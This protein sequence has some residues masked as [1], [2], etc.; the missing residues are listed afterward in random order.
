MNYDLLIQQEGWEIKGKGESGQ[1]IAEGQI[2]EYTHPFAIHS[3][4][5]R[6]S[7][8]P[9]IKFNHL[10]AM[11]RYAWPDYEETWNY[12]DERR[13]RALCRGY[14]Y[15]SYAGG[16]STGKSDCAGRLALLY[17]LCA[18]HKRTV[19]VA[20]TT[21]GSAQR[22]IWGYIT[23]LRSE[24]KI[25][26][27]FQAY[28]GNNPRL[29]YNKDD[30][31]HGMYAVAAGRGTDEKVISNWIGNHPKEAIL[32]ILDEATELEP[33]LLKSLVN[34]ES[35][36]I[37][38]C[39]MA[40]GNS[41][42]RNDLHGMM[43]TPKIGWEKLDPD[44]TNEWE[45]TQKNG[46]CLYFNCDESP[47]IFEKNADKKKKLSRFFITETQIAEKKKLY[48]EKGVSYLRF[49]KGLW[50][51]ENVDETIVS[52]TFINDFN[53]R[54]NAEWFG[55]ERMQMCAGLDPAFSQGGDKCILQMG[56]LGTDTAGNVVLDFRNGKLRHEVPVLVG[57]KSI[58]LQICEYVLRLLRQYK[59]SLGS[60]CIDA[61][62]QG[63]ALGELLRQTAMNLG[64]SD[65]STEMPLKI[66]STKAGSVKQKSFDVIIKTNYELWSTVKAFIQTRQLRGVDPITVSQLT[67]RM[68]TT[69][70]G[71]Q[72]L[73]AKTEYKTRMGGINP[74]LAHSPD[75]ADAV[76]LCLQAAI[77]R[78]GFRIGQRMEIPRVDSFADMKMYALQ[79]EQEAEAARK[80]AARG[81]PEANFQSFYEIAQ[82]KPPFT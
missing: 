49:V 11:Q 64:Y 62:G 4:L 3:K 70:N 66:Y 58:E 54:E 39:C 7:T 45:T 21:L 46:I 79:K 55:V 69:K 1:I 8:N 42:S 47:A 15:I 77:L 26:L 57:P 32:V 33:A 67:S 78:F 40:L 68:V 31:I 25:P 16:A 63:R 60:L 9:D 48:G 80:K 38:F 71:Q 5:Y 2:F 13:F 35:G 43:S 61:N 10:Y 30:P 36:G 24:L 76:A 12:W 41:N 23:R 37:E 27:Q 34:L 22:R 59:C 17:W 81:L 20:S 82:Y 50:P 51:A 52:K 65:L 72:I 75:E 19:I 29:V 53:V 28:S 73:E 74:S 14:N 6:S 18:P 44:K 56:I